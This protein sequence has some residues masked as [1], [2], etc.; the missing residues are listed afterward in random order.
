MA[1]LAKF[2]PDAVFCAN[3]YMAAGAIKFLTESGMRI[4]DHVAV[5]G[6]DNNDISIGV[7]PAL[8]T[9]DNRLKE[10]GECIAETLL[11]LIKGNKDLVHQSLV[12]T[13]VERRSH[14]DSRGSWPLP[15]GEGF[16]CRS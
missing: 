10:A 3:D 4:P 5:V 7:V 1:E 6:Y 13:L 16:S 8:T 15:R 2:R 12:P 9:V 11:E 14:G